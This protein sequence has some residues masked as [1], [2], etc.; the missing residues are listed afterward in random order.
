MTSPHE[1]FSDRLD[2]IKHEGIHRTLPQMR[3]EGKYIS[4]EGRKM[5]NLSSNNYLGLHSNDDELRQ[6]FDPWSYP[7]SSASSRLL[8]GNDDPYTHFE[9]VLREAYGAPSALLWGSG[10]HANT[11]LLPAFVGNNSGDTLIL[12]DRLVHASIIEGIRLSRASF[13]RFRHNDTQHLAELLEQNSH[14]YHLIWIVTE[15]LFSMDG[16][17]A[18]LTEIVHLKRQ[19]PNTLL[20]LDEAH[21]VGVYHAQGLGYAAA[22][23]LLPHVDLL[24]GT[25]GKALGA[26]GAFTLQSQLLREIAVSTARPLIYST[27]LPPITIAW[28]MHLF[29]R[30]M[31]MQERRQQLQQHIALVQ[32]ELPHLPITSHI[33]PIPAPGADSAIRLAS[34]LQEQGYYVRPIRKPTV[35]AGSERVR[36]SLTADLTPNEVAQFCKNLKAIL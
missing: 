26:A 25:L 15:S 18:P 21:S 34:K 22:F 19:Y 28:G 13:I 11:G 9:G 35:P 1:I 12:A 17:L 24:V 4:V 14:K 31:T 27:A 32:T 10:Y 20:Y 8:T 5:L 29:K 7:W 6:G 2:A 33:I 30:I 23:G 36:I 16:D 3:L